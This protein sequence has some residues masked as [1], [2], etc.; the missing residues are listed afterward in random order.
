[1]KGT[2]NLKNGWLQNLSLLKRTGPV[3]ADYEDKVVTL[4][5]NLGFNV[6]DVRIAH[7]DHLLSKILQNIDLSLIDDII[8]KCQ[9]SQF[10]FQF[11]VQ[12]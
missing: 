2:I 1:M 7:S 12:L 10:S 6:L 4:N 5:M 3:T 8:D 11:S 9:V